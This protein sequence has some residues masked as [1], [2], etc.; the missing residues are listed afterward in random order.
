MQ[1]L[2]KYNY[3]LI[4]VQLRFLSN[5]ENTF[6]RLQYKLF[7]CYRKRND[8]YALRYGDILFVFNILNK[9]LLTERN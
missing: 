6:E 4:Y 2:A 3:H 9:S 7:S 1:S 8:L 5:R